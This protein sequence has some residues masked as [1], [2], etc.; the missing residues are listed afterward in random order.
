[1]HVLQIVTNNLLLI[2]LLDDNTLFE[3]LIQPMTKSCYN[4]LTSLC[5]APTFEGFTIV[6]LNRHNSHST[7]H[8]KQVKISF[9]LNTPSVNSHLIVETDLNS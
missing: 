4:D 1:M 5:C 6:S 2:T 7:H 3:Q 9:P 8:L